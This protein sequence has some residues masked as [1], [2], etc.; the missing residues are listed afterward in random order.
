[1]LSTDP[2]RSLIDPTLAAATTP[3][4]TS[5][6]GS[7]GAASRQ[8]GGRRYCMYYAATNH[9]DPILS[10]VLT[11][12]SHLQHHHRRRRRRR[13]HRRH[14]R[15]HHQQQQQQPAQPLTSFLAQPT[16]AGPS[17]TSQPQSEGGILV[18]PGAPRKQRTRVYDRP[19]G[20][21]TSQVRSAHRILV[22]IVLT[23]SPICLRRSY[24]IERLALSFDSLSP[25]SVVR[26]SRL[27]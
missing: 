27:F 8:G 7:T 13:H 10:D 24:V 9:F 14:H 4:P 2:G 20:E 19:K 6:R 3:T 18:A 11:S 21:G 15:H 22:S 12:Y 17:S 26:R 25:S 16:A 5:T 23:Q 1:M